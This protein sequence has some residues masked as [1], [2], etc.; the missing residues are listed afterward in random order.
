MRLLNTLHVI[1]TA[2]CLCVA[3]AAPVSALNLDEAK[4][5]GLVGEKHNGIDSNDRRGV[6][7]NRSALGYG[8]GGAAAAVLVLAVAAVA[9][10]KRKG[11]GLES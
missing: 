1:T 8:A 11:K 6:R 10:R 9:K 7:T 2:A 4:S 3:V 5:Q